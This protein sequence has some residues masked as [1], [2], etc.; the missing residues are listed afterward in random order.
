MHDH[1]MPL[2]LV[3]QAWLGWSDTFA[4]RVRGVVAGASAAGGTAAALVGRSMV[5]RTKSIGSP[6]EATDAAALPATLLFNFGFFGG[7]HL[8]GCADHQIQCL[9]SMAKAA[10]W[11]S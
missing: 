1:S 6:V 4:G 2:A 8:H 10:S 9:R 7:Y 3:A 5:S 11:R